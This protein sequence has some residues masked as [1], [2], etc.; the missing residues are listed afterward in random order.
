LLQ[1]FGFA[2][3]TPSDGVVILSEANDLLFSEMSKSFCVR[4]LGYTS[5]AAGAPLIR[6]L[7]E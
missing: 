5:E 6:V 7:G 4:N 2:C 1:P 3:N